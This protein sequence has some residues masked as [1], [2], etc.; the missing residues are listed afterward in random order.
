MLIHRAYKYRIYP[1]KEQE[2]ALAIQ[3]GHV[4]FV[5]N[6]GLAARKA[7]FF[8]QG[9]GLGYND[10][11]YMLTLIKRF[12]PWLKEAD[13]QVLQQSLKDLDQAYANYFE[14]IK[15]GT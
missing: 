11:A 8:D 1:N 3:F 7:H 4:R 12:V 13:S 10:T 14:M 6:W 9:K 15:S 5:Y 2:A